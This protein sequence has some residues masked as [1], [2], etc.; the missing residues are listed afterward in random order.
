MGKYSNEEV[1]KHLPTVILTFF[2][3]FLKFTNISEEC[4]RFTKIAEEDPKVFHLKI[5][6]NEYYVTRSIP[7]EKH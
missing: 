2:E 7:C 6:L 5:S 3:Y 1:F 4:R